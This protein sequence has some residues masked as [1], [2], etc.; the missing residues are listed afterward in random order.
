VTP[1]KPSD[2]ELL[3]KTYN[4]LERRER[5]K[6]NSA[7]R[8]KTVKEPRPLHSTFYSSFGSTSNRETERWACRHSRKHRVTCNSLEFNSVKVVV[9]NTRMRH[10]V[11]DSVNFILN[12]FELYTERTR[13]LAQREAEASRSN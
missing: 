4:I 9:K 12:N 13:L 3:S 2:L 5:L 8:S 6:Q 1:N 10:S 11:S 7:N